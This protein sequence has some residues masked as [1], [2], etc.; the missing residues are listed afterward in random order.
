MDST[1]P[2]FCRPRAHAAGDGFVV[3]ERLAGARIHAANGEIVHGAGG[4]RGNS[5]RH[6]L[7]H[8]AQQDINNPLRCFHVTA[9]NRRRWPS[10]HDGPQRRDDFDGAHQPGGG[11]NIFRQQT[12]EDVEAR[13]VSNGRHGIDA[14]GYLRRAA[15]EI[16]CDRGTPRTPTPDGDGNGDPYRPRRDAVVIEKILG[17]ISSWR[18]AAQK[19]SHQLLRV[20][21]QF[22]GGVVDAR[23]S[24]AAAKLAQP[25]GSR[26]ARGELRAQVAITFGGCADVVQ[27]QRQCIA[28]QFAGAE[29]ANGR[30]AHA[31]LIDLAA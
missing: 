21:Q 2:S 14:A 24:V 3:S 16:Y 29:Q 15:G 13:R 7:R 9:G 26:V 8:R 11:R 20:I 4:R 5:I 17:A 27:Q 18:D 19:G 25:F 23:Q 6:G 1:H 12:A 10:V 30:N 22:G 31:F 28:L